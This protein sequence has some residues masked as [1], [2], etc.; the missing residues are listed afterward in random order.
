MACS[1]R[2]YNR[3]IFRY[4]ACM[5]ITK[6]NTI[7]SAHVLVANAYLLGISQHIRLDGLEG[8]SNFLGNEGG[9]GSDSDILEQLLAAITEPRGLRLWV[10]STYTQRIIQNRVMKTSIFHARIYEKP[11]S[12]LHKSKT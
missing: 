3:D 7:Q 2:V 1:K 10:M 11:R 4:F 9:T 6:K 8:Y 12:I 5:L